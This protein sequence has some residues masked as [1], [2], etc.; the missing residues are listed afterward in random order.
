MSKNRSKKFFLRRKGMKKNIIVVSLLVIIIASLSVMGL[1]IK[2]VISDNR[3]TF[4][5]VKIFYFFTKISNE[6]IKGSLKD[7]DRN[8]KN[9]KKITIRKK[10]V[11]K[12]IEEN[13]RISKSFD[14]INFE[15]AIADKIILG[16]EKDKTKNTPSSRDSLISLLA[17]ITGK[18]SEIAEKQQ[19]IQ[20]S[21]ILEFS[22][23]FGYRWMNK[24][25]FIRR[26]VPYI[27]I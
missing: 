3:V 26:P 22:K 13:E 20:I 12:L 27:S 4:D 10:E 1:R 25:D 17:R 19:D 23:K 18:Q 2:K 16:M 15:V 7:L 8:L 6:E 11:Q 14:E 24:Q 5:E 9:F 21:F